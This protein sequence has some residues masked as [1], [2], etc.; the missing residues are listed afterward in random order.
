MNSQLHKKDKAE[1]SLEYVSRKFLIL[2]KIVRHWLVLRT[3]PSTGFSVSV[4]K[5]CQGSLS[6]DLS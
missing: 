1:I 4:Q 6:I 5:E 3:V 2:C